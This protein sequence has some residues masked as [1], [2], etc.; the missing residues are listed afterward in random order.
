METDRRNSL[1]VSVEIPCEWRFVPQPV[2]PNI[3]A[4]LFTSKTHA[5]LME[6]ISSLQ[7]ERD[8]LPRLQQHGSP[9]VTDSNAEIYHRMHLLDEK[10]TFLIQ[11]LCFA[12]P[13]KQPIEI[14]HEGIGITENAKSE[15]PN[16]IAFHAVLPGARHFFTAGSIVHSREGVSNRHV[17]VRFASDSGANLHQWNRFVLQSS[18]VN[19]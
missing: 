15:T 16:H 6:A 14:C 9:M 12:T 2:A 17:G 8:D 1:W 10:L 7:R 4:N 13:H 19:P 5:P 3:V 18:R 11:H